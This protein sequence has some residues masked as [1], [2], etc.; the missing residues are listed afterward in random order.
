MRLSQIVQGPLSSLHHLV[1]L[2]VVIQG[3][4][5]CPQAPASLPEHEFQAIQLLFPRPVSSWPWVQNAT[6]V[7]DPKESAA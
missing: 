3:F 2:P 7:G 1:K 4:V 6:V 5:H